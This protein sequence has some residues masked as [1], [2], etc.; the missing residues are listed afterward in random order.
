MFLY[1]VTDTI[2]QSCE[3]REEEIK[4][5]AKLS[6]K[7]RKTQTF[8]V[9]FHTKQHTQFL[10]VFKM[11]SMQLS[12]FSTVFLITL[13]GRRHTSYLLLLMFASKLSMKL[14]IF[15]L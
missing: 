6:L 2:S 3:S 1:Y 11:V 7:Y 5:G 10:V 13:T 4:G 14:Y 8:T 15:L 9:V 12:L